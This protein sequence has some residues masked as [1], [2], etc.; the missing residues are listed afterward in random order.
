MLPLNV[1]LAVLFA[2]SSS[3][4]VGIA[5][6]LAFIQ[7][8]RRR[9]TRQRAPASWSE[10]HEIKRTQDFWATT[11]Y[12]TDREFRTQFR[13]TRAA[14]A[15]LVGLVTPYLATSPLSSLGRGDI[16]HCAAHLISRI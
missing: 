1:L 13:L 6:S 11:A 5:F 10:I 15:E 3:A 9:R 4:S 7:R 14:Y 12:M 16:A 8:R 2:S